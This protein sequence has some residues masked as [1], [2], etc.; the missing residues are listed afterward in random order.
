MVY[1]KIYRNVFIEEVLENDRYDTVE[2]L[3]KL[4]PDQYVEF[5]E[6]I[7]GVILKRNQQLKDIL[8]EDNRHE[9]F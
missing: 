6:Y 5:L 3:L 9:W 2:K 7:V 8:Q 1:D 4:Q